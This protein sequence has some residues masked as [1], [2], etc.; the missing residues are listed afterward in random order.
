MVL[1]VTI[2]SEARFGIAHVYLL[3][4]IRYGSIASVITMDLVSTLSRAGAVEDAEGLWKD[5]CGQSTLW[6]QLHVKADE[7]EE[8]TACLL[9]RRRVVHQHHKWL[10]RVL[11]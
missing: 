5:T 7:R 10:I 1:K 11:I 4:E 6:N 8:R 9:S 2:E 3:Q